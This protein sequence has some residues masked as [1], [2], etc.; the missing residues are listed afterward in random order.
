MK[1]PAE[2]WLKFLLIEDPTRTS[3]ELQSEISGKGFLQPPLEYFA[4]LKESISPTPAVFNPYD[5]S[6]RPSVRY[7]RKEGVYELFFPT[8]DVRAA[9]AIIHKVN[10]REHVEALI[11]SRLPLKE[12]AKKLN[13]KYSWDLTEETL[14]AYRHFYWNRDLLTFD[15]WGRFLYNRTS[16][17]EK[18]MTS[19]QATMDL[20]LYEL[21]LNS[22][23]DSKHMIS[24]VQHIAYFTLEAVGLKPGTGQDKVKAIGILG[25]TII[26]AHVALSTS[27]MQIKEV[28]E[29]FKNFRM[30]NP[31]KTAPALQLLA[32]RGNHSGSGVEDPDSK[33]KQP[34][35]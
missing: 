11:L 7:L 2:Y 19:I 14:K 29:Q 33:K 35:H 5:R 9:N 17:Y 6:H 18:Y 1:H 4:F 16:M 31:E 20:A 10:V 15:E 3:A 30:G 12:T 23:I 28:L 32:P 21:R 34:V 27:D 22:V 24:R 8:P 13:Q 25:K 26:D